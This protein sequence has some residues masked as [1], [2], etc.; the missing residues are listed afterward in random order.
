MPFFESEG[1]QIAY[2]ADE[3]GAPIVLLHGFATQYQRNWDGTGWVK[4]LRDQGRRVIRFDSR[5]HGAS[6]RPHDVSSYSDGKMSGD[7]LRLMDHLGIERADALGYSMGGWM[8][9]PLIAARADRIHSAVVAGAGAPLPE[10]RTMHAAI[11]AVMEDAPMPEG[12]SA[13][14]RAIATGFRAFAQASGNDLTALTCVLRSGALGGPDLRTLQSCSMPVLV[15]AGENDPIAGD[16]RSMAAVIPGAKLVVVPG[17]D[18]LNTLS[19]PLF[20][21]AILEF[22]QEKGLRV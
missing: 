6:S 17:A 4:A 15:V 1:L 13:I 2:E 19:A 7:V 11:T 18:H 16:P 9:L 10:T 12:C 3:E 21:D 14:D 22:L 20:R 5:G 8:L